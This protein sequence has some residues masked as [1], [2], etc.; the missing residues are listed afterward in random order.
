MCRNSINRTS[1]F[2]TAIGLICIGSTVNAQENPRPG[3]Q[4]SYEVGGV[5]YCNSSFDH[6]I[7]NLLVSTPIGKRTVRQVCGDIEDVLE[8]MDAYHTMTSS[9]AMGQLITQATKIPVDVRVALT[10]VMPAAISLAQ[11]GIWMPYTTLPPRQNQPC[12]TFC[13]QSRRVICWNRSD[14]VLSASDNEGGLHNAIDGDTS[15]RWS[16]RQTQREGQFFQI[17]MSSVETISRVVLN[18]TGSRNDFPREFTVLLSTDGNNFES[19]AA[20]TGYDKITVIDFAAQDAQ[21]VR[22]EQSGSSNR[23]WWSIHELN[24]FRTAQDASLEA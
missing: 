16:T 20:G 4:D 2:I 15:T 24:V 21:Y 18:T 3:Y 1:K 10:S 12:P 7:A 5:C 14:W 23:F 9:A 13:L 8:V 22:I 17:D 11:N 6:G 19:V